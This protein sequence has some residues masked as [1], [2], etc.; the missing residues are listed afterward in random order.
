M[1]L[2]VLQEDLSKVLATSIRFISTRS[3]LPILGNFLLIAEKT[4]L[5]VQA[6]NLEMSI[7]TSIGAKVTEEGR[8]TAPAKTLQE[9]ISNLNLGQLNISLD[10]EQL[11]IE[12]S[13]FTGKLTTTPANDFPN[14]PENITENGSFS[15]SSK[16]LI[17]SLSKVLFSASLDE[18]R[19]ILG[20]VLFI[21]EENSLTLVASDG[22]R[23]SQKKIGLTQSL[24]SKRI[25]IPRSSLI[26]LIKVAEKGENIEFQVRQNDNQLIM[27]V[28]DVCL[29]SRLIEGEFP[30]FEKIIPKS[31][32]TV[33]ALDK[34]DLSRGVKLAS[35][36][37]REE[38]NVIKLTVTEEAL[39]LSSQNAKAGTQTNK[40]EA[41]V[42]GGVLD[43]SYNYKFIEDFINV[44]EGEDLE[45]HLTDSASPAIFKDPK[46][47]SFLHLIMPVRVQS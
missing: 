28:G 27:K 18:T 8:V 43:I 13:G 41:K 2:Q 1:E 24:E 45:I 36:F 21:F 26:E 44:V 23:L 42:E 39:E 9:L 3:T 11:K 25:V 6:T 32:G 35:V 29:A 20:G 46:D 34:R 40:V 47:P 38:G 15:L 10:K 31:P 12:S 5:K 30:N 7:S 37:A 4:K 17:S 22:F 14:I 33:V 16:E 19:P